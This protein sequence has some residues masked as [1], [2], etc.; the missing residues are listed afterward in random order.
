MLGKI[1]FKKQLI[2][3]YLMSLLRKDVES[4]DPLTPRSILNL[5]YIMMNQ[6]AYHHYQLDTDDIFDFKKSTGEKTSLKSVIDGLNKASHKKM[7]AVVC[8]TDFKLETSNYL[9]VKTGIHF[10][11]VVF[12]RDLGEKINVYVRVQPPKQAESPEKSKNVDLKVV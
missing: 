12:K 10:Y 1:N 5:G 8:N 2:R 9:Q 3:P 7:R 6:P 11:K 4:Y